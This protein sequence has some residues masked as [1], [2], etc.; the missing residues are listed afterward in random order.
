RRM[1]EKVG[2]PVIELKR[3]AIGRLQLDELPDGKLRK[4]TRDEIDLLKNEKSEKSD[5][6]EKR[7]ER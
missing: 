1:F 4:L 6:S 3:I 2:F 7:K 5:K